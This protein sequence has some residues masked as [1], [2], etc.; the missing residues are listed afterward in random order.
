MPVT[1][2]LGVETVAPSAGAVTASATGAG[3][4]ATV[5][6]G[7]ETG[8]GVPPHPVTDT[9]TRPLSR[10]VAKRDPDECTA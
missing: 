5:G 1:V 3:V 2:T 9:A 4:G 7:V 6:D 8:A 10:T